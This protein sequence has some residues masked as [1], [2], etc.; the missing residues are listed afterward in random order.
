MSSSC[1]LTTNCFIT[2][3]SDWNVPGLNLRIG[4]SDLFIARL[5]VIRP[6]NGDLSRG[7]W[8]SRK[9]ADHQ[10]FSKRDGKRWPSSP[11]SR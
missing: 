1:F 7:L 11:A 2:C 5:P 3:S 4:R 10:S 9:R 6:Q 8:W